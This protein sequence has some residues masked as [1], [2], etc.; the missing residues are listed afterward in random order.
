M[1]SR[2]TGQML[3]FFLYTAIVLF[4]FSCCCH[5][6]ED[7]VICE[8]IRHRTHKRLER[9]GFYTLNDGFSYPSTICCI[10]GCYVTKKYLFGT[11]E[12]ADA[13]FHS[14]IEQYL[15]PF[16]DNKMIRPYLENYPL[17][18][19]NLEIVLLFID[20]NGSIVPAPYI[21]TIRLIHGDVYYDVYDRS[22][23]TFSQVL[24][25]PFT[26]AENEKN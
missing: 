7:L 23:D 5:H 9:E 19:S 13:F 16:N 11:L 2:V 17:D 21:A 6:R 14:F 26:R 25:K 18:A 10:R 20:D 4:T 1:R 24:R 22:T 15:E 3:R 8:Q 12:Q